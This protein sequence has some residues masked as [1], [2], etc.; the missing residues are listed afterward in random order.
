MNQVVRHWASSRQ[1]DWGS[2]S[3]GYRP[4][5]DDEVTG[6]TDI[7]HCEATGQVAGDRRTIPA[8][9]PLP[10]NLNLGGLRHR[11]RRR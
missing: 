9:L 6:R 2:S 10:F 11:Q 8:V 7:P 1:A 3:S 5:L 4:R